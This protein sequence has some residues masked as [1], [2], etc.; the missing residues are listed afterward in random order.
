MAILYPPGDS[1]VM[2]MAIMA[3]AMR[4]LEIISVSKPFERTRSPDNVPQAPLFV[5]IKDT[6]QPAA[7]TKGSCGVTGNAEEYLG[8][9]CSAMRTDWR[10]WTFALRL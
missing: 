7:A 5:N 2:M 1:P 3:I 4:V 6:A 10:V 8:H 9:S